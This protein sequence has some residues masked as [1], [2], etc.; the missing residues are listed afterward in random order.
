MKRRCRAVDVARPKVDGGRPFDGC[1]NVCL[2]TEVEYTE[3]VG[4][5][6]QASKAEGLGRLEDGWSPHPG[7]RE[8]GEFH[9]AEA[10][11]I[12]RARHGGGGGKMGHPMTKKC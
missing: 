1:Q 10:N 5:E 7:G 2:L 6:V 8:C 12:A 9:R 11:R 4:D 3:P